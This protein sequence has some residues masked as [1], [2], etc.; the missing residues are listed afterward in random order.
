MGREEREGGGNQTVDSFKT[1]FNTQVVSVKLSAT[2]WRRERSSTKTK[3]GK[4]EKK[5]VTVVRADNGSDIRS[6]RAG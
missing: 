4:T 6:R 2:R 5:R 3:L 1:V